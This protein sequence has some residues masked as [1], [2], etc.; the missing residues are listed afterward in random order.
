MS[1]DRTA[2]HPSNS[3][4]IIARQKDLRRCLR[5]GIFGCRLRRRHQQS[6]R[7]NMQVYG[8]DCSR[9]CRCRCRCRRRRQIQRKQNYYIWLDGRMRE[10]PANRARLLLSNAFAF[11]VVVDAATLMLMLIVR[12]ERCN[13]VNCEGVS[14]CASRFHDAIWKISP[15]VALAG[16]KLAPQR[17]WC[18]R[19]TFT[20]HSVITSD[21]AV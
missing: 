21:A 11:R 5:A 16:C 1:T 13:L 9:H 20:R 12:R 8:C 4:S 7:I 14:K 18:T 3:M 6:I 15:I 19:K 17:N 10:K 2:Q